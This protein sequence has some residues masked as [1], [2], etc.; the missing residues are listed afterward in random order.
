MIKIDLD[1]LAIP[2]TQDVV[3]LLH[4]S[5]PSPTFSPTLLTVQPTYAFA[6][7]GSIRRSQSARLQ[8]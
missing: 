7:A 4:H 3:L 8:V 1:C 2:E 5:P 6:R